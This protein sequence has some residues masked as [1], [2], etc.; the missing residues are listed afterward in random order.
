VRAPR[1]LRAVLG[2][3]VVAVVAVLGLLLVDGPSESP[4]TDPSTS[5][6]STSASSTSGLPSVSAAALPPE[7]REVLAAIDAGGPFAYPE[8]D[9]AHFGNYE[10]LLPAEPSGYYAE[11]TVPTPGQSG[12]GARRIIAGDGGE[13]Y[14]TA[15]HYASFAVVT[16]SA[17]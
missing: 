1:N 6:T 7:A 8:R 3:V 10:G 5:G 2:A 15:D 13:R 17:G 14:W 9:G 4:S 11:Y 12:R 16:R